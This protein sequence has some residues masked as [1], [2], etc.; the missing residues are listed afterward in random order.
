MPQRKYLINASK[1]VDPDIN[2]EKLSTYNF[3]SC[4]YNAERSRNNKLDK[5][6]ENV[7]KFKNLTKTKKCIREE[8]KSRLNS[9]NAC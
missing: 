4:H 5:S 2:T 8:I 1:E 9:R 3:V 6:L 7:Q